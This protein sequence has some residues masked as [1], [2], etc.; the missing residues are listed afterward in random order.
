KSW[1]V[2]VILS[3]EFAKSEWCQWEVDVVQERRRRYGRDV[4]L[5]IML[6]NIDSNH[7]TN[8]LRAILY[9]GPSLRYQTGVGEDLFWAVAIETL[10]KPLEHLPTALV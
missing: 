5:L 1:K 2:V 10:R 6:K 4:F 7:M 9:S 8:Q 3:N